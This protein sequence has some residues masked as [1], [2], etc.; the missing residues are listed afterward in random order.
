MAYTEDKA[1]GLIEFAHEKGRLGH[2][3]II[4]GTKHAGVESLTTRVINLI[5]REEGS[6]E[7]GEGGG[8][9]MFDLFGETKEAGD[10]PQSQPEAQNL[11][12]LEGELVRIVR[13]QMKSRIISVDAMRE[14]EKSFFK[15]ARKGKYKVGVIVDADRMRKE[16]ANAFLKTLEEPPDGSILF[17]LTASPE[18]LLSTILSRCVN[19]PLIAENDVR[20]VMEGEKE[21]LNTLLRNAK[22]GFN[23]VSRALTIKSVFASILNKR[24]LAIGKVY[25]A[26]LKEEQDHYKN[27]TDGEWLKDREKHYECLTHSDYLFERSKFIDLLILWLGD[28]VRIKSGATRLDFVQHEAAMAEAAAKESL[29]SLLLRMDAMEELRGL[30]ETNVSEALALEVCFMKAFA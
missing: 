27:T 17:L 2:A 11:Q 13:P 19:I 28:L 26:S 10:T 12:E 3:F 4:S 8:D 22:I 18:R 14:L 23:S 1:F 7:A 30:F 6:Q 15:T 20:E 21:M 29:E 5:N 24:K 16:A 9:D 25:E